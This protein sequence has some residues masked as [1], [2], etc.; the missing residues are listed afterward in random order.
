MVSTRFIRSESEF[1]FDDRRDRVEKS[2]LKVKI[3]HIIDLKKK[4]KW[5]SK[6]I[7][8]RSASKQDNE[9]TGSKNS[10]KMR[11][12]MC[13]LYI[14]MKCDSLAQVQFSLSRM[15]IMMMRRF[16][17]LKDSPLVQTTFF[18]LFSSFVDCKLFHFRI[19]LLFLPMLAG[20]TARTRFDNV[21]ESEF[22]K[23]FQF[24]NFSPLA[25][26]LLCLL[27]VRH[28]VLMN[29]WEISSKRQLASILFSETSLLR[30]R[31][32]TYSWHHNDLRC[33]SSGN[34]L[35]VPRFLFFFISNI[36][37]LQ[38]PKFESDSAL[39]REPSSTRLNSIGSLDCQLIHSIGWDILLLWNRRRRRLFFM[40]G[41]QEHNRENQIEI[42]LMRSAIRFTDKFDSTLHCVYVL[43]G[44]CG[45]G[46]K[47]NK[48]SHI[49]CKINRKTWRRENEKR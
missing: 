38:C 20:I 16:Q 45:S 43:F 47:A 35:C 22:E 23:I 32:L 25:Q 37:C 29:C 46:K 27:R 7:E 3:Q 10:L 8:I 18:L 40:V 17:F 12:L 33:L 26:P 42:H 13:F 39:V 11:W 31:M 14:T 36:I 34:W 48:G 15:A 24:P 49:F 5:K 28:S 6:E 19:F 30:S 21:N 9:K 41:K 4:K 44:Y 1:F 2:N